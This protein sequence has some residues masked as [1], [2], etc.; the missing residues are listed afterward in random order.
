MF[1]LN[2]G[3]VFVLIA[4]VVIVKKKKSKFL[5]FLTRSVENAFF[6]LAAE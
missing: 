4:A 6:S 3:G 2:Y 5:V 1:H